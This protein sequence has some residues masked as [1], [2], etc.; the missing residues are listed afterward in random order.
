MANT[1]VFTTPVGVDR[2]KV[3]RQTKDGRLFAINCR[4]RDD[5]RTTPSFYFARGTGANYYNQRVCMSFCPLS[6]RTSQQ[7]VS[8]S[9]DGRPFGH[10][11]R[12]AKWEAT[13]PLYVGVLG[14]HLTLRGL[15]RGLPP[16]QA[17]SWSIQSFGQNRHGPKWRLYALFGKS[18]IPI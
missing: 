18:W 12:A 16:Y 11:R 17:A 13:V 14:P 8:T 15:V 2:R 3:L 10:S 9:W 1:D 7:E 6:A 4:R 5:N